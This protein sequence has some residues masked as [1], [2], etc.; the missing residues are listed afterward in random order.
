MNKKEQLLAL[1]RMQN[2]ISAQQQAEI[3]AMF[4]NKDFDLNQYLVQN[5][6]IEEEK[7][8]EIWAAIY[9]LPYFNALNEEI[10]EAIMGLLPEALAR[11]YSVVC[12]GK[13]KNTLKFGII[14]PNL[15]AME[16]VNF[17]AQGQKLNPQYYI[18]SPSSLE[19]VMKQYQKMEE[20][21]S[22]A[23]EAKTKEEGEDLV[24]VRQDKEGINLNDDEINS[25]P[26]AKIV[27][28][29]IRHAVEARASD[30]HIEPYDRESR[31]RY[32]ID[33]ILHTSLTLPKSIHSAVIA[34]VKVM[35][36][37]K[38]D[39]TRIP[40]DGR[41]RLLI[42]GKEIDFRVSTL[43]LS[44]SEK[45]VM[46]ILDSTKGAP[47]L[48]A[49]GF[50]QN[51]LRCIKS[52]ILKTSGMILVTGPTGSG[53][54]TTLY[55]I[56]NLLNQEGVNISTLEDPI[57]YEIK[58]INQSQVQPRIGFSFASG[59]RS[60]LRQDPNIIMV[61]EI[62]DE[63]TAE[64]ATHASLTGHL[65]LSTLH[66]NDALSSIFR[67]IDMK[68]ENFLLASTLRAIIA[69]RLVRQVCPFC[70][71]ERAMI[72]TEAKVIADSLADLPASIIQKEIP[73][74]QGPQFILTVPC[75]DPVGCPRCENTG[76]LNRI[77][78]SE[79][80]EINEKLREF[81]MD[82]KQS[83]TLKTVKDTQEFV[84]IKQDGMIKVLK[85]LTTLEEV[86]RVMDV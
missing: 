37:L 11:T 80:I 10:P 38:L 76:Y 15:K 35:A 29:V 78:I 12:L 75:F 40:Q 59:L 6:I 51:S 65:V 54:T 81:I 69:Q 13:E 34:R 43:P 22:S 32:R 14:E 48:E 50:N 21:I 20:E 31:V 63:E 27:S 68:V 52:N 16:A 62:R 58:G 46:R 33:G 19:K 39:E 67:L 56:L 23:L 53:K 70:R 7:L 42:D 28:V 26:V 44:N 72:D 74:W 30:I 24:Q 66:T 79:T 8:F 2:I 36:K 9:S 84:A 77:A 86:L 17:L 49:L 73:E 83:V 57:E 3:S 55:A 5:K 47:A 25:A 45:V 61:G 18:I 1:L 60:L 4:E 85:G 82:G 71:K 41:I 64:L